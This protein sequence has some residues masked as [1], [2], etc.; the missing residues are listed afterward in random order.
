MVFFPAI[1]SCPI[2]PTP[3][4]LFPLALLTLPTFLNTFGHQFQSKKSMLLGWSDPVDG[5]ID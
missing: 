2:Y 1:L 5:I 4:Q 3:N